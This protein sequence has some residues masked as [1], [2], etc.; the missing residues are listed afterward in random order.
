MGCD[1]GPSFMSLHPK[2]AILPNCSGQIQL[3]MGKQQENRTNNLHYH[4]AGFFKPQD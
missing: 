1:M 2:K 4:K 3:F